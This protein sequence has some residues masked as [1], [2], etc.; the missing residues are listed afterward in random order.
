MIDDED[1]DSDP[2]N[3]EV[4]VQDEYDL[5]NSVD[6][7]V[8]RLDQFDEY[9]HLRDKVTQCHQSNPSYFQALINE[10]LTT[11]KQREYLK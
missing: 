1:V 11:A 8:T 5:A 2:E 9:K 3:S 4:F 10:G 6:Q 7:M